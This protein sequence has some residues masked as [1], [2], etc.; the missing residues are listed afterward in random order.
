MQ[1][2]PVESRIDVLRGDERIPAVILQWDESPDDIE[3]VKLTIVIQGEEMSAQSDRGYFRALI[4]IRSRLEQAGMLLECFGAS[5]H[6]YPSPMI[7]GMGGG[8]K[9]YKLT[10]GK[11]AKMS[12][13][14]N[15]FDT[16]SDV[17]PATITQQQDFYNQWL[18]SL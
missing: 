3:S 14:V 7:E 10:L 15:I 5:E 16:G 18:K 12:D 11:P 8:E 1:S 17:R 9:A 6:V 4:Q 2:A 13:L